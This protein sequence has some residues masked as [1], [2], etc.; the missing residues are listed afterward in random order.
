MMNDRMIDLPHGRATALAG[1]EGSRIQLEASVVTSS[2]S[3]GIVFQ[4][5]RTEAARLFGDLA[6]ALDVPERAWRTL[7]ALAQQEERTI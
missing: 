1:K 2:E 4:L 6:R 3:V 5:D 7:T